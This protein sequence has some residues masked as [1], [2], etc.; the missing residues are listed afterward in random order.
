MDF[1]K[2][3]DKNIPVLSI[4]VEKMNREKERLQFLLANENKKNG[5]IQ[6]PKQKKQEISLGI[7]KVYTEHVQENSVPCVKNIKE[8]VG[9]RVCHLSSD[10]RGKT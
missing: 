8:M 4:P 10:E 1:E 9:K 5:D 3:S 6:E 7:R 2:C